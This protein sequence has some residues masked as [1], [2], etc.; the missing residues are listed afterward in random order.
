MYAVILMATMASG[1]DTP[2]LGRPLPLFA[3]VRGG[4]NGRHGWLAETVREVR[5]RQPVR[6]LLRTTGCTGAGYEATTTRT[7]TKTWAK[8]PISIPSASAVPPPVASA[9][10]V[11]EGPVRKAAFNVLFRKA[12]EQSN[13]PTAKEVL[14]N[15]EL[16]DV[17]AKAAHRDLSRKVAAQTPANTVGRLGDGVLLKILIDNL[18]AI[19]DAARKIKELLGM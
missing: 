4:C 10:P 16:F 15:P 19:L 7:V 11:M 6:S 1:S 5:S 9:P 18:P 12:L 17:V 13:S 8:L 14:A 3:L 2:A